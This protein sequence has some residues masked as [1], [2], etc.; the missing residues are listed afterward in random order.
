MSWLKLVLLSW[1][2][3]RVS[4]GAGLSVLLPLTSQALGAGWL[5]GMLVGWMPVRCLGRCQKTTEKDMGLWVKVGV[6]KVEPREY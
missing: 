1:L 4:V 3:V 5:Q 2:V 6:A